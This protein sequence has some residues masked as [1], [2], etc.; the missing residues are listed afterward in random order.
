[1]APAPRQAV[2][3]TARRTHVGDPAAADQHADPGEERDEAGDSRL[4]RRTSAAPPRPPPAGTEREHGDVGQS[5]D[6]QQHLHL[7]RRIQHEGGRLRAQQ[8]DAD[9][10]ANPNPEA[11]TGR[12]SDPGRS[13]GSAVGRPISRRSNAAIAPNRREKPAMWIVST[14][15][16]SAGGRAHS[17][18]HRGVFQ[19]GEPAALRPGM[20]DVR[21]QPRSPKPRH[22]PGS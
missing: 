22:R 12:T 3:P 5:D 13:A 7:K 2:A 15:G 20:A 10:A 9:G 14:V 21:H 17:L 6:Q 16:N 1:M 19:G 8:Q 18:A 11:A 4:H